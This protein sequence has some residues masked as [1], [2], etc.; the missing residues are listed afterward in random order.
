MVHKL[1]AETE[2]VTPT[3]TKQDQIVARSTQKPHSADLSK[4]VHLKHI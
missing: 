2:G 4:T 3:G 1:M